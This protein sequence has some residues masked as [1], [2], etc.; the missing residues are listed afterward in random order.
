MTRPVAV[1]VRPEELSHHALSGHANP[2]AEHY[3]LLYRDVTGP[4]QVAFRQ[5]LVC[6]FHCGDGSAARRTPMEGKLSRELPRELPKNCHALLKA[7]DASVCVHHALDGSG[8]HRLFGCGSHD[9][10]VVIV[11][12]IA[13]V[14][15]ILLLLLLMLL[16]LLFVTLVRLWLPR[17]GCCDRCCCCC[18]CCFLLLLLLFRCRCVLLERDCVF[19]LRRHPPLR[20][21]HRSSLARQYRSTMPVSTSL[22][23]DD[24]LYWGH[25]SMRSRLTAF[26]LGRVGSNI[27]A[28]LGLAAT[29]QFE[30]IVMATLCMWRW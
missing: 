23:F 28:L 18:C 14:A 6:A 8:I 22:R 9:V 3:E 2:P 4:V 25:Q 12:V 17:C 7:F 20:V 10:V 30:P 19:L 13:F 29:R 27:S 15:I 11:V 16:L 21:G 24:K 1:N 5:L 26:R